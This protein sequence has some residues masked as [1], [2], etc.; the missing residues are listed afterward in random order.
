MTGTLLDD[1]GR[2]L[3][4]PMPRSQALRLIGATLFVAMFPRR[5]AAFT[6]DDPQQQCMTGTQCCIT[7]GATTSTPAAC[8]KAN[9]YCCKVQNSTPLP[10]AS[11]KCCGL[12]QS[13]G[14]DSNGQAVCND[15]P[16]GQA[17]CGCSSNWICGGV[18]LEPGQT[19]LNV[20]GQACPNTQV[21]GGVCCPTGQSC[22]RGVCCSDCGGVCLQQGQTCLNG[23]VCPSRKVCGSVCLEPGQT[24]LK[25]G[26][27]ACPNTQVCGGVCCPTGT[28]CFAF[29]VCR[30]C[31]TKQI[32][33]NE[34]CPPGTTC[35][36][37][38]SR[39]APSGH[40]CVRTLH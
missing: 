27:K 37:V 40:L 13:C 22:V 2:V 20:G 24:C 6:C 33:G 38:P 16:S 39:I 17:G 5:A 4:T 12:N 34:C 11:V 7:T 35:R 19:C 32:C 14:E 15:C 36:H 8:C 31:P 26:G 3:A 30:K 23:T 9:E 25:V 29:G 18:C 1:L 28:S 21:C 10:L